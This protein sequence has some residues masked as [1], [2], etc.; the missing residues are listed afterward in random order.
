[1][2]CWMWLVITQIVGLQWARSSSNKFIQGNTDDYYKKVK[3]KNKILIE[4]SST[5]NWLKINTEKQLIEKISW[6][7][8]WN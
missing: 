7:V 6:I 8:N 3:I 2:Y 4:I 5:I 1:M